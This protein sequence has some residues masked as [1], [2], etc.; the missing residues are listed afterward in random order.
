MSTRA[1]GLLLVL[2]EPGAVPLDEFHRWYDTEHAPA[3]IRVPGVHGGHRFRAADHRSP[4]W[5]A[6]YPLELAAL[7]SPAYTAARERSPYEQT[8]V[9]RLAVLDRRVYERI[10]GAGEPAPDACPLLLTVALTSTDPEGLDA[11]YAG[12]HLP[13]LRQVP[14]WLRTV[15]YRRVEG[16]GPDQLA[17]HELDGPAVFETPQYARA[18]ATPWREAVARTVSA[19]ERRLFTHHR[20]LG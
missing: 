6:V 18:V 4:G 20:R 9:E 10:D 8:V 11:W 12:E 3:R 13:M 5:L 14:G 15:R 17:V 1:D 19:R 2:S 7:S 16:A